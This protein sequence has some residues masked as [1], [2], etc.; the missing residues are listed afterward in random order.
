M[1]EKTQGFWS[2]LLLEEFVESLEWA[3]SPLPLIIPP[4][5]QLA[6]M[7]ANMVPASLRRPGRVHLTPPVLPY[8]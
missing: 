3:R 4:P 8:H 5:D 6:D 7:A 2:D 1:A